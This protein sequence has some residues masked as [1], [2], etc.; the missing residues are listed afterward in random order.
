MA[1]TFDTIANGEQSSQ[2]LYSPL[3]LSQCPRRH[4]SLRMLPVHSLDK[5]RR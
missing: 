1:I 5:E 2:S 4:H 3:L